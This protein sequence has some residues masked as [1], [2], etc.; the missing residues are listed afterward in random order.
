MRPLTALRSYVSD[1][2][3]YGSI[4]EETRSEL[5]LALENTSECWKF[6]LQKAR[7]VVE[8]ESFIVKTTLTRSQ[9]PTSGNQR[10]AFI[11]FAGAVCRRLQC[12][13]FEYQMSHSD[14]LRNRYRSNGKPPVEG[15][16]VWYTDYDMRTQFQDNPLTSRHI[17]SIRDVDYYMDMNE[18][19]SENFQPVLLY[20]FMPEMTAGAEKVEIH[21]EKSGLHISGLDH[22]WSFVDDTHVRVSY[23]GGDTYTHELWDWTKSNVRVVGRHYVATY[24]VV[25]RRVGMNRAVVYLHPMRRWPKSHATMSRLSHIEHNLLKRRN[26]GT[27]IANYVWMEYNGRLSISMYNAETCT[28][29][30]KK[31]YDLAMASTITMEQLTVA[32]IKAVLD[33]SEDKT[34]RNTAVIMAAF[35][36]AAIMHC[37]SRDSA[38]MHLKIFDA[39][40]PVTLT[41]HGRVP[42]MHVYTGAVDTEAAG[43]MKQ[44]ADPI[45]KGGWIHQKSWTNE[46]GAAQSRLSAMGKPTRDPNIRNEFKYLLLDYARELVPEL[47]TLDPVGPEV[48][49]AK[50]SSPVQQQRLKDVLNGFSDI[51]TRNFIKPF[52]K[53]ETY[54]K[55]AF[56]RVISQVSSGFMMEMSSLV[57]AMAPYRKV[58]LQFRQ[59]PK[60]SVP[61]VPH[62]PYAFGISAGEVSAQMVRLTADVDEVIVTDFSDFDATQN[63]L[64]MGL[65]KLWYQYWFRNEYVD[66]IEEIMRSQAHIPGYFRNGWK[67]D[68]HWTRKSGGPDTSDGNTFLNQFVSYVTLRRCSLNHTDSMRYLGIY[69]G[70]DGVS[71]IPNH[72]GREKYIDTLNRTVKDLGM[73]LK[74]ADVRTRENND[75]VDFLGRYYRPW[76]GDQESMLDVA[77]AANKLMT[78]SQRVLNDIGPVE[79]FWLKCYAYFLTDRNTPF[80][81]N[82]VSLV[83][84]SAPDRVKAELLEQADMEA[85]G[86][87]YVKNRFTYYHA[88]T[89]KHPPNSYRDWFQ[90]E[91]TLAIDQD[92]S[93]YLFEV[94]RILKAKSHH[95]PLVSEYDLWKTRMTR[96]LAIR[97]WFTPDPEPVTP[98]K[99]GFST[100]T[101]QKDDDENTVH[102]DIVEPN[103]DPH[104]DKVVAVENNKKGN[105]WHCPDRTGLSPKGKLLKKKYFKSYAAALLDFARNFCLTHGVLVRNDGSQLKI[106]DGYALR[107][108][109]AYYGKFPNG[110]LGSVDSPQQ[111]L[112]GNRGVLTIY[113]RWFAINHGEYTL[114]MDGADPAGFPFSE[115]NKVKAG[116]CVLADSPG[117]DSKSFTIRDKSNKS[118]FVTESSDELVRKFQDALVEPTDLVFDKSNRRKGCERTFQLQGAK[119]S[120]FPEKWKQLLQGYVIEADEGYEIPPGMLLTVNLVLVQLPSD[121]WIAVFSTTSYR[122]PTDNDP[123]RY[124]YLRSDIASAPDKAVLSFIE[125]N[126]LADVFPDGPAAE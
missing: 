90:D 50:L 107:F 63:H 37:G 103:V 22:T 49:S 41:T 58:P 38:R 56:P 106:S 18:F 26:F 14:Q 102:A 29:F 60:D 122:A 67:Y 98:M 79:I 124:V 74:E 43:Q 85:M 72:V 115:V 96:V 69:G 40:R 2:A 44:I 75:R 25:Q 101:I 45:W 94:E 65:Q 34:D 20:T 6:S 39:L 15:S 21:D 97:A 110:T 10:S 80:L 91:V 62:I 71:P 99:K 76:N 77:R 125:K 17:I 24:N 117:K 87:R 52:V 109:S 3:Y 57:L 119:Y 33:L 100:V 95:G 86:E 104:Y 73:T 54:G 118:W 12:T 13:V 55:L 111:L 7:E 59:L 83:V 66:H 78:V 8:G 9:H 11:K 27:G 113:Q 105:L 68:S 19:L 53:A 120:S 36:K 35:Y 123:D 88:G 28:N 61:T 108:M 121:H 82:L 89:D 46:R 112:G 31:V 30:S 81:G 47:N 92:Y 48:V 64:T 4:F 1:V 51:F 114:W 93:K 23:S 116:H 84:N 5:H 42:Y 126:D 16:R 70:D 32:S